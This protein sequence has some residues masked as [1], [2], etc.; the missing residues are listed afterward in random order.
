MGNIVGQRGQV[1]IPKPIREQLGI[2][3]GWV[4][5]PRVVGNR[6]EITFL[7]PE[8]SASLGG[9]LSAYARPDLETDDAL[10]DA[11][12]EA[13]TLAARDELDVEAAP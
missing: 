3:P 1:V 9:A 5:M 4:A 10:H 8:H 7:P 6:V 2:E 11:M 13:W 12:D